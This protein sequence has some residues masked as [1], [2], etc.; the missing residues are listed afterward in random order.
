MNLK[1]RR[2]V[3]CATGGAA[4]SVVWCIRTLDK[5]IFA[6]RT[7]FLISGVIG[8][9]FRVDNIPDYLFSAGLLLH[10]TICFEN[11]WVAKRSA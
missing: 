4:Q 9:A 3:S 5:S 11:W 6:L 10:F 1:R 8:A 7:A 2:Q